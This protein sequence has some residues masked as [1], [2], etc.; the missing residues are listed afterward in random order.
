MLCFLKMLW[1]WFLHSS[2]MIIL[3]HLVMMVMM[4]KMMMTVVWPA[5][6]T[7]AYGRHLYFRV[8]GPCGSFVATSWPQCSCVW[9]GGGTER[10]KNILTRS[11]LSIL[12]SKY[13]IRGAPASLTHVWVYMWHARPWHLMCD[14]L[15]K[16]MAT[17]C[18]Q[19][20][21]IFSAVFKTCFFM[22]S[23]TKVDFWNLCVV[24]ELT[25]DWLKECRQLDLALPF[26]CEVWT[27]V[28]SLLYISLYI[29]N[30]HTQV[31]V[32]LVVWFRNH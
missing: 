10:R 3:M 1:W 25:D 7:A 30:N 19:E 22:V 26:R 28:W 21:A 17:S 18:R 12:S 8:V 15:P 9:S 16:N 2:S 14:A 23:C 6:V 20:V 13:E 11:V 32:F 29:S 24:W 5:L 27:G 4:M 31:G